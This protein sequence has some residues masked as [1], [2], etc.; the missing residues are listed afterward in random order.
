VQVEGQY[1]GIEEV[2]LVIEAALLLD[3]VFEIVIPVARLPGFPRSVGKTQI[4]AA[5][6]G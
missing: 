2:L 3:G 4:R 6:I 5:L 1:Q